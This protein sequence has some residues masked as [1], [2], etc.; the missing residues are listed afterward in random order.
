MTP[1]PNACPFLTPHGMSYPD[2]PH[3]ASII[4]SRLSAAG[5]PNA[6]HAHAAYHA[7]PFARTVNGAAED[8]HVAVHARSRIENPGGTRRVRFLGL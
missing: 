4:T 1:R 8:L 6:S 7:D 2:Q 5:I 3:C